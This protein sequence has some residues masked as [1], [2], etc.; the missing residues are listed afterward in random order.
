MCNAHRQGITH[1]TFDD[2]IGSFGLQSQITGNQN[3]AI[4]FAALRHLMNQPGNESVTP[5]GQC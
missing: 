3:P 5:L 4:V 2:I 1:P